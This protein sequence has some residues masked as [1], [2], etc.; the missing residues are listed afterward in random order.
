MQLTSFSACVQQLAKGVTRKELK[1]KPV[2]TKEADNQPQKAIVVALKSKLG[3]KRA[4]VAAIGNLLGG[5]SANPSTT[6]C[7]KKPVE[8]AMKETG[9]ARNTPL[10]KF[11]SPKVQAEFFMWKHRSLDALAVFYADKHK[12]DSATRRRSHSPSAKKRARRFA[13]KSC[14]RTS[15]R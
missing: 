5:N 9:A 7:W 15:S 4:L 14:S 8:A 10:R 2:R 6:G 11:V 12:F 3:W 13:S 1:N